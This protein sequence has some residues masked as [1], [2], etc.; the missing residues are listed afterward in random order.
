MKD[1]W[2][3][4][5]AG[6]PVQSLG[7]RIYSAAYKDKVAKLHPGQKAIITTGHAETARLKEALQS[8][9]GCY[10]KKPYLIDDIG[11]AVKSE[12]KIA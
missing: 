10:L 3:S 5:R 8:G 2:I 6:N 11:L 12:L 1:A 7:N 9:V 4:L